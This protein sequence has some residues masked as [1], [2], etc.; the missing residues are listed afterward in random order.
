[1][2]LT[3]RRVASFFKGSLLFTHTTLSSVPPLSTVVD[4]FRFD[5]RGC[6][7]S[8]LTWNQHL[9]NSYSRG[10]HALYLELRQC[11][12]LTVK[13]RFRKTCSQSF[14]HHTKALALSFWTYS[15]R[16]VPNYQEP[17]K[18]L[19]KIH[20]CWQDSNPVRLISSPTLYPL[21]HCAPFINSVI[22]DPIKINKLDE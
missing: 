12:A 21:G 17:E 7:V 1:M 9:T 2:L 14:G 8:R 6:R 10:S 18:K 11:P 16:W 4:R 19:G 5:S 15:F 3:P 20:W 13:L 22:D